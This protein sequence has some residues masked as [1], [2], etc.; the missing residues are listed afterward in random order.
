MSVWHDRV[1]NFASTKLSSYF[2]RTHSFRLDELAPPPRASLDEDFRVMGSVVSSVNSLCHPA[3]FGA[4]GK[5][6]SPARDF[7]RYSCRYPVTNIHTILIRNKLESGPPSVYAMC[8]KIVKEKTPINEIYISD[9]TS[10]N[11]TRV[12][13]RIILLIIFKRPDT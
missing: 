8:A 1:G 3:T 10:T 4:H 13:E 12:S 2:S 11:R 6:L 5:H 9:V 7:L